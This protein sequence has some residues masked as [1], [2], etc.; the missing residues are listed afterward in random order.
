MPK[1]E[2]WVQFVNT[3]LELKAKD[4]TKERLFKHWIEGKGA[5][6]KEARWSIA[7]DLL[8]WVK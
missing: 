4:G 1:D 5:N 2:A 7:K 8:H 6:L 3:W